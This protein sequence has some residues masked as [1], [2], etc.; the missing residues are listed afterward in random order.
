MQIF[1]GSRNCS[2]LKRTDAKQNLLTG[3]Y[4]DRL[5]VFA[6]NWKIITLRTASMEESKPALPDREAWDT[7]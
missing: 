7:D 2:P 6:D 3:P 5:D 1:P 4:L